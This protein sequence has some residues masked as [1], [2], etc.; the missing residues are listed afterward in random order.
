MNFN[1]TLFF[2]SAPYGGG[3]Y[4]NWLLDGVIVTLSLAITA[5]IIAFVIGSLI[6]IMRTSKNRFINLFAVSYIEFFRNIPLLIQMF[7]WYMLIPKLLSGSFKI[8]FMQHLHPNIHIFILA[9][10]ALG[11]FTSARIAEQVRTGIQ[12]LPLG[13][14]YAGLALGLS[15]YQIYRYILMPNAYRK[16]IP[17]LTSEMTNI[18]KNSS[19]AS[20]IGLLDIIGQIPRINEATESIIPILCGITL[21]YIIIN[22]SIIVIMRKV[23]QKTRLPNMASG[24]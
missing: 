2:Q 14:S 23:E 24:G 1:W 12:T 6:G 19:V 18:V 11:L 21:T 8:W 17:T 4:L 15:K 16:I 22:Y 10:F 3:I 7:I 13:Q 9:S 20:T 5:W